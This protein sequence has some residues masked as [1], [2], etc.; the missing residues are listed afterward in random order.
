MPSTM[1]D[2]ITAD[3]AE[4][5]LVQAQGRLGHQVHLVAAEPHLWF[6][7]FNDGHGY[8][9]EWSESWGRLV[10]IAVLGFPPAEHERKV[11]NLAL[12]YNALWRQVGNLR[13]AR[14]GSGGE[15]LL[16][17]ELGP[18]EADPHVFDAALLR[19]D[20]LRRWWGDAL[21]GD[22]DDFRFPETPPSLW[23]G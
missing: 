22:D 23:V 2:L 4:R 9:I 17:G 19:F 8:R 11:L 5:L 21:T 10:L 12:A 14:D 7:V 15:L 1:P 6:A 16:I 18:E 13:M 3:D 20:S